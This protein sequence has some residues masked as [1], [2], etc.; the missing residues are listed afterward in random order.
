MVSGVLA[1]F[2]LAL[3]SNQRPEMGWG[4]GPGGCRGGCKGG[5]YDPAEWGRTSASGVEGHGLLTNC[6]DQ[7]ATANHGRMQLLRH[8]QF[9]L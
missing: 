1:E 8:L 2:H 3:P 4:R 5:Q 6:M 9:P 7:F